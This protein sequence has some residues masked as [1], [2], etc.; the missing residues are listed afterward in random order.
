MHPLLRKP[1]N[2]SICRCRKCEIIAF[3]GFFVCRGSCVSCYHHNCTNLNINSLNAIISNT[4]IHWFCNVMDTITDMHRKFEY[5]LQQIESFFRR[6]EAILY[7]R[8]REEEV[9]GIGWAF[10]TWELING[11]QSSRA[12][13]SRSDIF[14]RC[15]S[16]TSSA[17]PL[18]NLEGALNEVVIDYDVAGGINASSALICAAFQPLPVSKLSSESAVAL[19]EAIPSAFQP[20]APISH[21]IR[22][23]TAA[24]PVKKKQRTLLLHN[25]FFSD[26]TRCN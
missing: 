3:S 5:L 25:T 2:S 12:D 20:P 18:S 13:V 16:K 10:W 6:L 17:A 11:S 24:A 8:F 9:F 19:L 7:S 1:L 23:A 22:A 14:G 21:R 26:S 15:P 4:F